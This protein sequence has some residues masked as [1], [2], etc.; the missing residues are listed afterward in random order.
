LFVHACVLDHP[1]S[2]VDATADQLSWGAAALEQFLIREEPGLRSYRARRYL[3][4][5]NQRFNARGELDAITEFTQ[6]G[7]FHYQILRESGSRH[8]RDKVL[9][10]VLRDEAAL[11]RRGDPRRNALTPENYTFE[12]GADASTVDEVRVIITPRR[13]DILLVDGALFLSAG[14]GDLRRVEGRLAKNPSFWTSRV[15]VVRRYARVEGVR[16]PFATEAVAHVRV[17]GRSEFAMTYE[18]ESINGR[19]V[20]TANDPV[21]RSA[22][23][24]TAP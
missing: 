23:T 20:E 8:V 12:P 16:V 17:A 2:S 13:R 22:V 9:R 3:R 21:I 14:D 10:P 6:D 19:P 24:L 7:A 15:D 11:W 18:Y 5:E 1:V 4:A